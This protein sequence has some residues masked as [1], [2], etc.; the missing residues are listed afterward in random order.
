MVP[1]NRHLLNTAVSSDETF[2][3]MRYGK[4]VAPA[5]P[6]V[7]SKMIVSLP[8]LSIAASYSESHTTDAICCYKDYASNNWPVFA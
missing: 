7:Q 1:D 8:F 5:P 3:S 2:D 6:L 4:Q